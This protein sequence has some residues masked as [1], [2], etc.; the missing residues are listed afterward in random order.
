MPV[1]FVHGVPETAAIWSELIAALSR[2]DVITL[3]PPGFGVPVPS[4][5]EPSSDGY[6]DWLIGELEAM[7]EPVDLVGHDWGGG[8]VLRV[9]MERPDLIRSWAS[10]I[11]GAMDPD[12]EWHELARTWQTPFIG[13][14]SLAM[15]VGAPMS[16]RVQQ[17][18]SLGMGRAAEAVAAAMNTDMTRC[19]LALYR[20]AKQP[21][22]RTWGA[23]LEKASARPGLVI[24]AEKDTYCGGSALAKKSA[25]RC[26]ARF[27]E[28]TGRGHWWMCE[29]PADS[30]RVL[31]EFFASL[32]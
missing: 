8:H 27:V 25:E 22:M 2:T 24:A 21:A 30:A 4:G 10:D 29:D 20:S 3:S 32:G 16:M 12:Y 18:Q 15:A 9:A 11:A 26:G 23:S 31:N 14:T 6:R 17:F 28:L 5:F 19:I 1:V 13:E 7:G